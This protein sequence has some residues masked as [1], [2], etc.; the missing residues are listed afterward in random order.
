[1]CI[2]HNYCHSISLT[3]VS[4]GHSPKRQMNKSALATVSVWFNNLQ[5]FVYFWCTVLVQFLILLKDKNPKC[6]N[7]PKSLLP[8]IPKATERSGDVDQLEQLLTLNSMWFPNKW[9]RKILHICRLLLRRY[10]NSRSW[11]LFCMEIF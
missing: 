6:F 7:Y 4:C 8:T 1:M 10:T 3:L 9:K 11:S 5:E 2:G